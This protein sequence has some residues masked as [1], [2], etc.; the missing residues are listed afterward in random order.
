MIR[1]VLPILLLISIV[2]IT[3]GSTQ[4]PPSDGDSRRPIARQ[5]SL[6][7]VFDTTGSMSYELEQVRREAKAIVEYAAKMPTN[8]FYNYIFVAFDDP[9]ELSTSKICQFLISAYLYEIYKGK[10]WFHSKKFDFF[11]C[12]K[13]VFTDKK[14]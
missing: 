13:H 12:L 11:F 7:I 5:R 14:S 1:N 4:L 6:V 3:F 10:Y 2:L 8:P 9:G